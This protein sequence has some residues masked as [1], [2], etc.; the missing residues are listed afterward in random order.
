MN[1]QTSNLLKAEVVNRFLY[2]LNYPESIGIQDPLN[3]HYREELCKRLIEQIQTQ[4]QSNQALQ[5]A[6]E[7]AGK[8][9]SVAFIS[10]VIDSN[11]R[12]VPYI[13]SDVEFANSCDQDILLCNCSPDTTMHPYRNDV[14]STEGYRI[15]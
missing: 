5:E 12:T 4:A 15:I 6:L 13:E 7:E 3:P 8:A 14:P 1:L 11:K 10:D 9:F 2:S